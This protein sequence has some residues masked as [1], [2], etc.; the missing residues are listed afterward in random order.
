MRCS[1]GYVESRARARVLFPPRV[2]AQFRANA[3]SKDPMGQSTL[4]SG[5]GMRE[6]RTASR[7]AVRVITRAWTGVRPY[8]GILAG[9]TWQTW[10]TWQRVSC[11]HAQER[12]MAAGWGTGGL[13]HGGD[14]R[15]ALWGRSLAR[16]EEEMRSSRTCGD[17]SARGAFRLVRPS[18]RDDSAMGSAML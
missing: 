11:A 18:G 10:Q 12:A 17:G 7:R 1:S 8:N 16:V 15:P 6:E 2:V 14:V 13:A 3:D 4:R 5:T 9:V